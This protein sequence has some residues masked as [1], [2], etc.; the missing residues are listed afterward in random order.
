MGITERSRPDACQAGS[1]A[2]DKAKTPLGESRV[3]LGKAPGGVDGDRRFN[4]R[5]CR[6]GKGSKQQRRLSGIYSP[7]DVRYKLG[8]AQRRSAPSLSN[9]PTSHP[10]NITLSVL[11]RG[12]R[13]G[14]R[15]AQIDDA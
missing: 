4:V 8:Q 13:C 5:T 12:V 11:E 6:R 14:P 3:F 1:F 9:A 2:P 10:F 15:E 7:G